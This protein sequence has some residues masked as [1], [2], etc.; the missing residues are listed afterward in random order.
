MGYGGS[1]VSVRLAIK[2]ASLLRQR[3]GVT[4]FAE[5][6]PKAGTPRISP[7]M[8]GRAG[9]RGPIRENRAAV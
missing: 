8:A 9:T 1:G 6:R 7:D 2:A 3:S 4:L 5:V